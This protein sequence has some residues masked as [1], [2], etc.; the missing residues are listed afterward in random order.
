M[1]T[2]HVEVHRA[3]ERVER[4][5]AVKCNRLRDILSYCRRAARAH[6]LD[7]EAWL[8]E[9]YNPGELYAVVPGNRRARITY[10]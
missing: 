1:A 6:G 10:F 8:Y 5:E 2:Y 7:A 9:A 3:G 4:T